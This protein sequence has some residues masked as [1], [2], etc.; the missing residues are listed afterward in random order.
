MTSPI[1][2]VTLDRYLI[3]QFFPVFLAAL[4]LFSMLVLLLD[5]FL[6]LT[7]FLSN[8]AGVPAILKVSLFYIPKCISYALPV[9]LL[10]A[11]AYT[12]GDLRAK[13]ELSTILGSGVPFWRFCL[14]LIMFG[15]IFSFFAFFFEDL[16]VIPAL[17]QK[18]RMSRELLGTYTENSSRIVIKLEGGRLIYSVD[19]FDFS[20]Q[21]L[22]GVTIIELDENKKLNSMV[23]ASR[24]EWQ[25]D[26]WS[27][28]SPV[29]YSWDKGF[30]RPSNADPQEINDLM[31]EKY[32]EEPETFRRSS[33][34]ASELNVRDAA[35]LIK[36]LRRAGLPVSSALADYHH[37]FSFS[38][39]SFVVIFL[40]LT[41]SGR[42][43]KNI[44]LLSLLASLGTAVIYYVVE[45][46]SMMSAQAGIIPPFW[47]AWTPVFI[48]T[49][50]GFFLLRFAKS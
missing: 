49:A 6:N 42:F 8:D 31:S 26:S 33:V 4:T 16:A 29:L 45:M 50:A 1:K 23:Y 7:R 9:S 44:L 43:N 40:S 25:E 27:F 47:G 11:S 3:R 36:D 28:V 13:N 12:L 19:F 30:L 21:T 32:R 18:N 35:M 48:C 38:A 5:L 2:P 41:I 15:I 37:R 10:F 24:A 17:R 14:S 20:S 39:V 46:L 34:A 22:S